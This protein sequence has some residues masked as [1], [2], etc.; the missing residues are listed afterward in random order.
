MKQRLANEGAEP[1]PMSVDDFNAFV[2]NEI[3]KWTKVVKERR[4]LPE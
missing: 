4:I 3:A 2:R 1:A